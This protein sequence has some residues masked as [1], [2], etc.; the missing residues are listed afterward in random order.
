MKYVALM[1]N[2][3]LLCNCSVKYFPAAKRNSMPLS[4]WRIEQNKKNV[5]LDYIYKNY[6]NND[7]NPA[8][9]KRFYYTPVVLNK[10][11][12][13]LYYVSNFTHRGPIYVIDTKDVITIITLGLT[14]EAS[15]DSIKLSLAKHGNQ[16]DA[17][18]RRKIMAD[19]IK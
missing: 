13:G 16:L 6:F 15:R 14:S 19:L 2:L 1:I 17:S 18:I 9:V 10:E 4:E 5:V 12:A 3:L 8:L 11:R 7:R